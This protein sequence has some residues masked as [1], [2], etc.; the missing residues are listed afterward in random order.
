M[1]SILCESR[2]IFDYSLSAKAKPNGAVG[3]GKREN[4][5]LKSDD[6]LLQLSPHQHQGQTAADRDEAHQAGR[7]DSPGERRGEPGDCRVSPGL[8]GGHQARPQC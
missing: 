7:E 2:G 6:E 4:N 5:K 3:A 8:R 1:T